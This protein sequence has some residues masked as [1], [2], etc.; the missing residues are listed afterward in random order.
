VTVT[1]IDPGKTK[2]DTAV[3]LPI[4]LDIKPGLCAPDLLVVP[5]ATSSQ[6][7]C[8]SSG[9]YSLSNNM[10][11]PNAVI[12]T[13][14]GTQVAPGK[15]TASTSGTLTIVAAASAPDYGLVPGSQTTWTVTFKKPTVCDLETL[16]LTGQS[17]T[18]LLIAADL[19]VVAGLAL[20]AVRAM[21]R[22]PEMI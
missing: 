6:I 13:V 7:G 10:K 21:R 1:V 4:T 5:A 22:R 15:Y 14:N 8:F 12:W 3:A 11:D 17:P 16:A 19:L 20:F 18:G 2:L 9:S